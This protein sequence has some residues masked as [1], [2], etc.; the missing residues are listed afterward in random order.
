MRRSVTLRAYDTVIRVH[1]FGQRRVRATDDA[2]GL[3]RPE[4]ALDV[5]ARFP[6]W[7]VLDEL[8]G[9]T[10]SEPLDPLAD[11]S[12]SR[13]VASDGE[14]RIVVEVVEQVVQVPAS[15]G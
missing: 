8:I 6:K 9:G 11:I 4:D 14:E 5:V 13:I 3:V 7:D 12:L 2:V 1:P 10:V 15:N